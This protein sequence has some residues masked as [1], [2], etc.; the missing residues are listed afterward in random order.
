MVIYVIWLMFEIGLGF[1]IGAM[2]H[3]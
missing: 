1:L 2:R 3:F